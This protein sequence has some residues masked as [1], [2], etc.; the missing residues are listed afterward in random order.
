MEPR[1]GMVAQRARAR[2]RTD[3]N[4]QRWQQVKELFHAALERDAGERPGYLTNR[5]ADDPELLR[6]VE[7]LLAQHEHAHGFLS[8]PALADTGDTGE[9]LDAGEAAR[10]DALAGQRIGHYAIERLL[11]K[12]GMGAVYMARDVRL[13]RRVALKLLAPRLALRED[14]VRRFQR[15]ARAGSALN[16]PNLVTVHEIGQLEDLYFIV[17]ELVDGQTIAARI[18]ERPFDCDELVNVATQVADALDEAHAS[19]VIHRDIKSSN[20]MLTHRGQVKILDLG[21]AKMHARQADSILTTSSGAHTG[22]GTIMGTV[23]FMSP[24]QSRGE[25]VDARTDLFSF[26]VVMYHMAC[27]RLPFVGATA[28]E[29]LEHIRSSDPEPVSRLNPRIPAELERIIGRCL[30]RQREQRYQ[31]ARAL[32]HDRRALARGSTAGRET[33]AGAARLRRRAWIGATTGV[34]IA[35]GLASVMIMGGRAG[36]IPTPAVSAA[37]A[38]QAAWLRPARFTQLTHHAGEE[39]FPHLGPDGSS[40]VYASRASGNWDIYYQ[41]IGGSNAFNLTADSAAGDHEPALSPDGAWIA[42]RSERDG[43]GIFLMEVTGE[44]VRRVSAVGAN[45]AWSPDGEELVFATFETRFPN[46][47][48]PGELWAVNIA[49]G[50]QRLVAGAD[51]AQPAWSPRGHR[52]AYWGLRPGSGQRDIWTVSATGGDPVPVTDDAF[53]DW[54][55]VWSP[56]G[57]QLYFASNRGGSMN[58]W[59]VAIDQ[60][61]GQVLGAPEPVTTPSSYAAHIS[62]SGD[63]KRMAYTHVLSRSNL[64][65]VG[66]Q[67][68]TETITGEPVWI[69]Q[70]SIRFRSPELSPDGQW[71]VAV[72]T[73]EANREDLFVMRADGSARRRLTDDDHRDRAPRWSP[74]GQRIGFYSDRSG[75]YE[76]WSIDANGSDLRQV[77]HTTGGDVYYPIWSPDGARLLYQHRGAGNFLIDADAPWAEQSPERLAPDEA[78]IFTP[79][80]WSPDGSKLAGGLRRHGPGPGAVAT[81]SLATGEYEQLTTAA[82]EPAVWLQDSRRLLIRDQGALS[83]VDS[84]SKRVRELLSVA[85]DEIGSLALSADDRTIYFDRVTTEADIWLADLE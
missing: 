68:D 56:D 45:P 65:R 77:T 31:R 53:L 63:G 44:S 10:L 32:G 48:R 51:A 74:D 47:R 35:A 39:I 59:R 79:W 76:I 60:V 83:L 42:F 4:P 33:S 38:A 18:D 30:A 58:L 17:T 81:Y 26:G 64:Q 7:S 61:T 41:R 73:D 27:G 85:P 82:L 62:F 20:I 80:S 57:A 37:S 1:S 15:E 19:G 69:T 9:L 23:P 28:L 13:G 29:I 25:E 72:A 70:G 21:L 8:R 6:E 50:A 2:A 5:C 75:K 55:P 52:I 67:P 66:F 49:S 36:P 12:G 11:G 14:R 84:H 43:G 78:A 22:L 34:A 3:M 40:F 54:N 24:E 71:L 16:H 46:H